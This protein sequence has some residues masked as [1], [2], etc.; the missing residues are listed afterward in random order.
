METKTP[1]N[2][3]SEGNHYFY[4]TVIH[5]ST[6]IVPV[7]TPKKIGQYSVNAIINHYISKFGPVQNLTTDKGTEKPNPEVAKCCILSNFCHS[8]RTSHNPRTN[9]LNEIQKN[10]RSYLRMFLHD[11]PKTSFH[12]KKFFA[13]PHEI[14]PITRLHVS[15]SEIVLHT[16]NSM[17]FHSNIFSKFVSRLYC[18]LHF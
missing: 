1:V 12:Q 15:Q 4:K 13:Y 10:L 11:T 2:P 8:P 6:Y 9:G 3:A 18:I 17:N 14:Q 7:L 5:F 16:L